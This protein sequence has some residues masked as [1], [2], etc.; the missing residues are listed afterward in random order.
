MALRAGFDPERI[1]LHGNNKTEA[2]LRYAI[3]AG[4]GHVIVDS[5]AEIDRARRAAGPPAGRADPGHA[6]HP[7]L[8]PLLRP[9]RAAR[10]EVRLRPRGRAGRAR[11]RRRCCA[12]RNLRLVG[13][14]AHIGSQIFELEPYAKA[15][16]A[17]AGLVDGDWDCRLLNVGGGLGIAYTAE[18]R[19]AVDRGLRRGQGPR[20]R[21][22][23]RP[24][25][26][27]PDR[28]GP[29]AG[30]QR[31]ASPRTRIGTV[32]EIPGVRTYVSV[33]GGMSDNMRPML[34]GSRYEAM[35]ANRAAATPD[36]VATV[37]GMHCESGDVLV[38]R[39][40]AGRR[41]APATCWSPR[42]P[43]P[44]AT[45]WRA[46]TTACPARRSS[47]AATAMPA[48]VVRR[49]TWDDLVARDAD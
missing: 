49:E 40:A 33:D 21:A 20:G 8:H 22:G 3:E 36:T 41:R 27:D 4:I 14:H 1:Y 28:A 29:L 9:D 45:R 17:L 47:S 26:A 42:R 30:R 15:I 10:L 37:A 23:V 6:R 48:L 24:G 12:S 25:A 13:L 16:E 44:T 7:A 39:R 43:V 5:F 38:T 31:R 19:A 11:R 32:K 35:I 46:T 2:E 34:Y 18:R